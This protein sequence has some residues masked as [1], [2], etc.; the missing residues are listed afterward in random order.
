MVM[1]YT[2]DNYYER[3]RQGDGA[4]RGID[5]GTKKIIEENEHEI[6]N[7]SIHSYALQMMRR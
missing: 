6:P 7:T 5:Q 4:P 2:D 3:F 1:V